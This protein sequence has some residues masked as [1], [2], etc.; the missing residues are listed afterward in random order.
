[1]E[2][3]RHLVITKDKHILFATVSVLTLHSYYLST[4]RCFCHRM[5]K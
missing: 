3:P 5:D 1:M 4:E 2:F